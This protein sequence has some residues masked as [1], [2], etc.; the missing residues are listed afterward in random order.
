MGN[1]LS[2]G[3]TVSRC[4][5]NEYIEILFRAKNCTNTVDVL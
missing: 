4:S 2:V 5:T 1:D 3:I